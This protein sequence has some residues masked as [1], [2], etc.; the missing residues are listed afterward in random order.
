MCLLIYRAIHHFWIES[1]VVDGCY[2][3]MCVFLCHGEV[4]VHGNLGNELEINSS[5]LSYV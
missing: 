5:F 4:P 1:M 3:E 2:L